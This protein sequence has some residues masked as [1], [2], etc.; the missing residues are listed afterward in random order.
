MCMGN[1]CA[2][3]P[4]ANLS[5]RE[6]HVRFLN[7]CAQFEEVVICLDCCRSRR[8]NTRASIIQIGCNT[9]WTG[10]NTQK[11]ML[12]FACAHHTEAYE[13]QN[14]DQSRDGYFTR[15][16]VSCLRGQANADNI[17][18]RTLKQY[19]ETTVPTLAAADGLNQQATVVFPFLP[20]EED[21]LFSTSKQEQTIAL[22]ISFTE[23]T[24]LAILSDGRLQPVDEW[25]CSQGEWQLNLPEGLYQ[26]KIKDS[27][28]Q[29]LLQLLSAQ[30]AQHVQL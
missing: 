9:P 24:G 18:W 29:L 3:Y 6:I 13:A 22:H 14:Q 27:Q 11:R 19:L 15:A 26:L 30:G 5:L 28:R 12:A 2:D 7:P 23:P 1:W 17:S 8:L 10:A 20:E 4:N 21:P 25:D 16:L